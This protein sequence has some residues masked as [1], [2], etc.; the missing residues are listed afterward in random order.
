MNG[1]RANKPLRDGWMTRV[2]SNTT[3]LACCTMVVNSE[4]TI[5]NK[6]TANQPNNRETGTQSLTTLVIKAPIRGNVLA[7]LFIQVTV[8]G[9]TVSG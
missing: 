1:V 6:L 4:S 9:G 8:M 3:P 5:V 2:T 7:I